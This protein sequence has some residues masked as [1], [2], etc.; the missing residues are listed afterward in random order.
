MRRLGVHPSFVHARTEYATTIAAIARKAKKFRLI[1]DARGD[2]LSEFA[3]TARHLSIPLRWLA[4]L[5]ASALSKRLL[6]SARHSDFAIFVSN[7][8]RSLQG[9]EFPVENT[10][11]VPSVADENIFYLDQ[12]LRKRT[13]QMLGYHETDIVITYVGS[14]SIWQCVP[15]TVDLMERALR[16]NPVCRV[17]IVTP[18]RDAF[19]KSFAHDLRDR[20][21]VTSGGLDDSNRYMNAADFGVLL[22]KPGSINWVAS[23][24]KF[25]EYSL[26]GLIVVTTDAVQQMTEI[27]QRLGNVIT[28][29]EF[30]KTHL[31]KSRSINN[32]L[33]IAEN[34]KTILGRSNYVQKLIAC[35]LPVIK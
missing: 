14:A 8:L 22:R 31:K 21:Y 24:V 2:T 20:V 7:A 23:P 18:A 13:R 30:M 26:T 16:E 19:E 6:D 11:I 27:G 1:W 33:D 4:P 34:A 25:A 28:S 17:L 3:E 5:K 10:L 12:E 32:R 29:N 15:E 35:Y 9:S